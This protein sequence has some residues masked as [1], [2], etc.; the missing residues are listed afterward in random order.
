MTKAKLKTVKDVVTEIGILE[1]ENCK[2]CKIR[3]DL[4]KSKKT[5]Q[6]IQNYCVTEC[7][8][9]K[10]IRA[11]GGIIEYG[12]V[13]NNHLKAPELTKEVY[14]E[15]REFMSD[16]EIRE[17]YRI[18]RMTLSRR[19]KS[20]GLLQ[21][22]YIYPRLVLPDMTREKLEELSREYSDQKIA[23]MYGV[24]KVT[25]RKRRRKWGITKEERYL[26]YKFTLQEYNYLSKRRGLTDAEIV[27]LW[28]I[29]ESSLF[30][31]KKNEW[32]IIQEKKN[33]T[34]EELEKMGLTREK[35]IEI[36]PFKSDKEI[37]DEYN[38]YER[39]VKKHRQ[40]L[41][42][43]HRFRRARYRVNPQELKGMLDR[44]MT[45]KAIG[46]HY[47]FHYS[48]ISAIIKELKEEKLL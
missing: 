46:E 13:A 19:K 32:K 15:L 20:W 25:I 28:R 10:K 26:K 5:P 3:A 21:A 38:L 31:L 47:G 11:L 1:D 41:G 48:T 4:K 12:A 45:K 18:G 16:M 34:P 14:I 40:R 17:K 43:S 33:P 8:I 44:G 37:A 35:L 22:K 6:E 29:S 9:G 24:S 23:D 27:K 7:K 39:T 36:V 2:G 30:S 42:V